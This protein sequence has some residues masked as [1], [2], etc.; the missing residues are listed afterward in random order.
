MSSESTDLGETDTS[1]DA[2]DSP[3]DVE[4]L[5]RDLLRMSTPEPHEG[6]E[7]TPKLLWVLVAMALFLGGIQLGRHWGVFGTATH[8]GFTTPGAPAT[9]APELTA[10]PLTGDAIYRA[11]CSPCH[12]ANAE[13]LAPSFPPLVGSEWVTGD[14]ETPIRIVLDGLTGPTQVRGA[15]YDGNMPAWGSMLTDEEIAAVLTYVRGLS[16]APPIDV[17]TVAKVRSEGR[18]AEPWTAPA[19]RAATSAGGGGRP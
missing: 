18:R 12:Q 11:R 10:R 4:R 7:P 5:H 2:L 19:L 1:A 14:V 17:A 6:E 8:V 13:G 16:S 9:L 3:I 15:R